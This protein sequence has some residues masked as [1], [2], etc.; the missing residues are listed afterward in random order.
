MYVSA[1]DRAY[2]SSAWHGSRCMAEQIVASPI[3]HLQD[4]TSTKSHRPEIGVIA[5]T[6]MQ[7]SSD[8]DA[9][10]LSHSPHFR[11]RCSLSAH[12]QHTPVLLPAEA[13]NARA[14]I[15]MICPLR[16]GNV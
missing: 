6:Q 10:Q 12:P 2:K 1:Q 11:T 5:N 15:P 3:T 4:R 9:L 7:C 13:L 14:Y 8:H 16:R